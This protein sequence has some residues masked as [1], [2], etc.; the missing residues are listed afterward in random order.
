VLR[1]ALLVSFLDARLLATI[2]LHNIPMSTRRAI[3]LPTLTNRSLTTQITTRKWL[4]IK[5][6]INFLVLAM[7]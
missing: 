6:Q 3:V 7:G 2:R 4:H 1:L 5:N